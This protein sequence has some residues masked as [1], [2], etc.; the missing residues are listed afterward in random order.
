MYTGCWCGYASYGVYTQTNN[1]YKR[2][3]VCTQTGIYTQNHG[4]AQVDVSTQIGVDTQLV[5]ISVNHDSLVRLT[6]LML[7]LR[8]TMVCIHIL[9]AHIH[10]LMVY[11]MT[12]PCIGI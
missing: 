1:V 8:K 7:C 3:G 12:I 5:S 9:R 6:K 2:V 10:R 4:Y 11:V